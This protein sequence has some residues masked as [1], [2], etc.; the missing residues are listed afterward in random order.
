VAI[1]YMVSIFMVYLRTVTYWV[2]AITMVGHT[3]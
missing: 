3:Y 2:E 1:Y